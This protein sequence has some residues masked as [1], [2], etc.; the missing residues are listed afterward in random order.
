MRPPMNAA[1]AQKPRLT[2]QP[3]RCHLFPRSSFGGRRRSR[4]PKNAESRSMRSLR[5][6]HHRG[7]ASLLLGDAP[8]YLRAEMADEALDRPGCRV[9]ERADG[10][11]FDLLRDLE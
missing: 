9:A 7:R 10:V 1:T 8:L 3:M 6:L 5:R 2:K 11:P 4:R